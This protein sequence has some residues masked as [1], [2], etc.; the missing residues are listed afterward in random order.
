[1]QLAKVR[2]PDGST[3]FGAIKE[4][5]VHFFSWPSMLGELLAGLGI[6]GAGLDGLSQ[7]PLGLGVVAALH[8]ADT[9]RR[10]LAA[11]H[12]RLRTHPAI[13]PATPRQRRRQEYADRMPHV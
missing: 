13:G 7:Q 12:Q 4:G 11:L 3:A 8:G 5:R 9:P 2:R 1:M 10:E 6:D